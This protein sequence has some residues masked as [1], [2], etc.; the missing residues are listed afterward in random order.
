METNMSPKQCFE[1]FNPV[2]SQDYHK[3]VNKWTNAI[4]E[5]TDG[6]YDEE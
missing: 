6:I 2:T 3:N 5:L 1:F 4:L